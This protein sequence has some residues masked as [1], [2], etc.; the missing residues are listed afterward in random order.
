MQMKKKSVLIYNKKGNMGKTS[1]AISLAHYLGADFYTN[2][3][4]NSTLEIYSGLFKGKDQEFKELK[5]DEKITIDDEKSNVFDFGGFLDNRI[6][7]VSKFVDWCIVPICYQSSADLTPSITSIINLEKYNK[8]IIILIN[9]TDKEYVEYLSTTLAKKFKYP[10]FVVNKSKYINKLA[11][12][13]KTI[14]DLS[15]TKGI[16]KFWI[17]PLVDQMKQFYSYLEK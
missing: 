11:D 6:I 1:H 3:I 15:Q 4:G 10:I 16:S 14:F 17:A 5:P 12:E 13:N 2:D 7:N 9:N 8:N